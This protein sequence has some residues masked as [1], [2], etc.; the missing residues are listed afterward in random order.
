MVIRPLTADDI[1]A[2][3]ELSLRAWAPVFDSFRAALGVAIYTALFPD[4]ESSQARAVEDV[5][6]DD[7]TAVWVAD[8]LDRAVG[9]V[10]V[11]VGDGEIHMPAV[12]PDHQRQGIGSALTS[13]AVERLREAGVTPAVVNTGGD[14]GHAPARRTYERAGFT[15]FPQV[16]HYRRLDGPNPLQGN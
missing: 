16:Q 8:R 13:F 15:A 10:A 3:V 7:A 12:D 14:P 1:G 2:V 9:F 4:W 5:C 6:R 11:R